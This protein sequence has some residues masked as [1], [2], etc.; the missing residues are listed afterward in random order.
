[1][2]GFPRTLHS[3]GGVFWCP[4]LDV[5]LRCLPKLTWGFGTQITLKWPLF[6]VENVIWEGRRNLLHTSVLPDYRVEI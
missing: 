5:Y 2:T 4:Y 3:W 6:S 1:M